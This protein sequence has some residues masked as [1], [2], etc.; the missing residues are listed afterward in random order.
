MDP[1]LGDWT[2]WIISTVSAAVL[3]L[4][5]LAVPAFRET[6]GRYVAGFVQHHFDERIE[7]LRSELRRS[8]EQFAAD[9]RANEQRFRSLA[10]TALSLRSSRQE[11]LDARRL[12]AVEKLWAATVATRRWL[13]VAGFVSGLNLD[14]LY[15]A[16]EEGDPKVQKLGETID[17]LTGHDLEIEA[18]AASAAAEQPF[19]SLE[20]WSFFSVYQGVMFHSLIIIKALSTGTVKYMKKKDTLKPL[21]LLA[22]PEYKDF[23]EKHGFGGYYHLLDIIEQK[24]LNA[25]REMLDGKEMDEVTLRR[26]AE[27]MSAVQEVQTS[28]ELEIPDEFQAP[29]VPDPAKT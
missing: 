16:A 27:I 1:Q 10:D 12:Q 4:A 6:I 24:L 11:A 21:M 26:S 28:P 25:I 18:Q 19:V 14:E 5:S 29:E 3:V 8:E 9:L 23:I 7:K 13:L 22:L 2:A 15:K 17:K 20:V